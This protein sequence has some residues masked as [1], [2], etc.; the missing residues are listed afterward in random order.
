MH[1]AALLIGQRKGLQL[2][3]GMLEADALLQWARFQAGKPEMLWLRRV[4]GTTA[5]IKSILR[6]KMMEQRE[7]SSNSNIID[8]QASIRIDNAGDINLNDL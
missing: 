7:R 8:L 3:Q 1:S 6:A 2:N 5:L 4:M